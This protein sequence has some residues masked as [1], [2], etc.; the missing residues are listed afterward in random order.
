MVADVN[1]PGENQTTATDWLVDL[2]KN[3][4]FGVDSRDTYLGV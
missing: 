2:C 4:F 3:Y 1:I